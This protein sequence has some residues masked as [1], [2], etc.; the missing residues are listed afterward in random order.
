MSIPVEPGI[1][2]FDG[3]EMT[4]V[5]G[6]VKQMS[7]KEAKKIF[8]KIMPAND[9]VNIYIIEWTTFAAMYQ[10]IGIRKDFLIEHSIKSK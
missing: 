8:E 1:A 2:Y 5:A 4:D 10:T 3:K 9:Q 7:L 6:G